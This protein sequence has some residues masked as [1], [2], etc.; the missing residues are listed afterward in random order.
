MQDNVK[1]WKQNVLFFNRSW[2]WESQLLADKEI[3]LFK[4]RTIYFY[5]QIL[6]P[7]TCY[8]RDALSR[9]VMCLRFNRACVTNSKGWTRILHVIVWVQWEQFWK[10]LLLVAT[11]YWHSWIQTTYHEGT[12]YQTGFP[13]SGGGGGGSFAGYVLLTSQNSY[14]II[15]SSMANYRPYLSHFWAGVIF[16]IP[17]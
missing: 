8:N 7:F 13:T 9:W 1:T 17:T 12:N 11:N 10:K 6:A 2:F 14:P 3:F 15:V 16:A 5:L 4:L